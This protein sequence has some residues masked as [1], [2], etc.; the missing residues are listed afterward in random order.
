M[1]SRVTRFFE[2]LPDMLEAIRYA[3]E[4]QGDFQAIM[5]VYD[6][7]RCRSMPY[8]IRYWNTLV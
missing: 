4:S 3:D 8:G 7:L 2:G 5:V 6:G 1:V